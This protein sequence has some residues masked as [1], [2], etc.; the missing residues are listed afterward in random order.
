MCY[1]IS[2]FLTCFVHL[3]TQRLDISNKSNIINC[4]TKGEPMHKEMTNVLS[5]GFTNYSDLIM[6]HCTRV[7]IYHTVP[8]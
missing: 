7:S 6:T 8:P 2:L 5:D 3:R 4:I 1:F